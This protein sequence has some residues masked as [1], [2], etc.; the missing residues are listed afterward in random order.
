[1]RW[2]QS[3]VVAFMRS[4]FSERVPDSD[5][6]QSPLLSLMGDSWGK[7]IDVAGPLEMHRQLNPRAAPSNGPRRQSRKSKRLWLRGAWGI[8]GSMTGL[9]APCDALRTTKRATS[10]LACLR[11]GSSGAVRAT[12]FKL[13]QLSEEASTARRFATDARQQAEP[14]SVELEVLE[15]CNTS[16]RLA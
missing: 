2:P 11:R 3:R 12:S 6:G 5:D 10:L 15:P 14:D 7:R 13:Q 1:M 4:L 9:D 8:P 16:T